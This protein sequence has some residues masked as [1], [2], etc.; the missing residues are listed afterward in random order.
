MIVQLPSAPSEQNPAK[1]YL[2]SLGTRKSRAGQASALNVLCA[3]A[4]AEKI[5]VSHEGPGHSHN[6]TWE[7]LPWQDLRPH[8]VRWLK[9]RMDEAGYEPA[10]K[11]KLLAALMGVFA[12]L[13][14]KHIITVE[15]LEE[16]RNV[17]WYSVPRKPAPPTRQPLPAQDFARMLL[18][19]RSD[20]TDTHR[21]RNDAVLWLLW[22]CGMRRAELCAVP[23][24]RSLEGLTVSKYDQRSGQLEITLKGNTRYI[25]VVGPARLALENWLVVRGLRAGAVFV[26]VKKSGELILDQPLSDNSIQ[27]IVKWRA[28]KASPPV[29]DVT[30]HRFRHNLVTT[31]DDLG[32]PP[33][34]LAK[35]LGHRQM[36]TILQYINPTDND[37]RAAMMKMPTP[38]E[39]K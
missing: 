36:A 30:Y 21:V 28:R 19:A 22:S 10:T 5:E 39:A 3:L 27:D 35:I 15:E 29:P 34:L 23:N 32:V 16:A 13:R 4:G 33:G 8:H 7:M 38:E 1:M 37:I 14:Q 9:G 6:I 2:D 20:Y 24:G 12:A 11:N 17:K 18:A 26:M 25:P 31:L